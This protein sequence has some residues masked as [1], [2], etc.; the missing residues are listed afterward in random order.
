MSK[1]KNQNANN[2]YIGTPTP[3]T[4]ADARATF[5]A[6]APVG[7]EQAPLAPGALPGAAKGSS[8][9]LS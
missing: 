7:A 2:N 8:I 1:P 5:S 3:L 6:A 9:Q 4:L